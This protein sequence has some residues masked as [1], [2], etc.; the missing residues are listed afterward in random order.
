MKRWYLEE[1]SFA[2]QQGWRAN[3]T[4]KPGG[5]KWGVVVGIYQRRLIKQEFKPIGSLYWLENNY[6]GHLEL[7]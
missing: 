2:S 1:V 5:L 3:A 7:S 4:F 6:T